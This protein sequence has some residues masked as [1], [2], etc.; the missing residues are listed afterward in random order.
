[1]I[2]DP[3]KVVSRT[4]LLATGALLLVFAR[5]VKELT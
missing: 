3:V 1:M 5:C 2:R 4:L